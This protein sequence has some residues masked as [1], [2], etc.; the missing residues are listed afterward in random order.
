MLRLR[1]VALV[2]GERDRVVDQLRAVLGIEVAYRDPEIGRLGL[3]NAVLPVGEQF[4]EVV[5]AVDPDT[6]AERYL[7]RRGGDSGYMVIIQTD[8]HAAHRQR[9]EE[10]GVRVVARFDAEGFT[11]MQLHPADTGGAFLEIDQQDGDGWHPAGPDWRQAVRT[12]VTRGIVGVELE[13]HDPTAV[14]PRWSQ[15]LG[16]PLDAGA[17]DAPPTLRLDGAA[18]SFVPTAG[19]RGEGL[20]GVGVDVAD[21]ELLQR[22]AE[23]AGLPADADGVVIGGVRFRAQPR[24]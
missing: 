14:G 1:Q 21:A 17:A 12:E 2:A 7:A 15:I 4:L 22:R 6:A 11:D 16:R 9:V 5:A 24:E 18:I 3:H 10:L 20:V 8:E 23:Q 13:C 19:E